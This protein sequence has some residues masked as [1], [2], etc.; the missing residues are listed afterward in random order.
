[1]S[2]CHAPPEVHVSP[3]RRRT[4]RDAEGDHRRVTCRTP[5]GHPAAAAFAA[6]FFSFL[7]SRTFCR[8]AGSTTSATDRCPSKA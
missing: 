1:M 4:Q 2:F 8:L 7:K 3:P 6:A 5:G